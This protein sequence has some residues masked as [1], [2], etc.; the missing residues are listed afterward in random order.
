M[1][2]NNTFSRIIAG[3][4]TW[5]SWGKKLATN[6]MMDLMNYCV[7]IGIT[8]FDHADIYGDYGNEEAFGKAFNLSGISR[9]EIQLISKC[10][11]QMTN[12]RPNKVAH[13][14]Y[15]SDYIIQSCERSLA[16]LQTDYL[17]LL[18][19]HRPSP[20]MHPEHVAKA[21]QRL[22]KEGK[23]KSFGVSNFS[24]SQVTLI[25]RDTAVEANQVEFSL[26]HLE[27]MYDGTFD[28]CITN[29]RMA[30]AWSPLGGYFREDGEVTK[31]IKKV[32]KGLVE[33]YQCNESQLLLAFMMKHPANVFA[34]VG[35]SQKERL[36]ESMEVASLQLEL[37]DWFLLL[38]ASHGHQVP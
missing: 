5:G 34:V 9:E 26:T 30:M 37:Q 23:I 15:D 38:E 35:T 29:D 22:K 4:M 36:K 16:A 17:D 20:L 13:Y 31:R 25:E 19:L 11:I 27:P 7:S 24:P 21:I 3:T 18:L 28:D 12:G 14:Q 32:M 33:K 6:E 1:Q 2:N 10:G 8:S